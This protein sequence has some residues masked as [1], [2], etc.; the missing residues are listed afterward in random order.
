MKLTRKEF[1]G[2][3]AASGAGSII[4]SGVTPAAAAS[5]KLEKA[6]IKGATAA[7]ARFIRQTTIG[8]APSAAVV[9]AK[10]CLIDGFGVMLAGSTVH[11]SAED[12]FARNRTVPG[13]VPVTV[14]A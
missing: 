12:S 13:T 14:G 3:V 5:K 7:V 4:G 2:V 11:G 1:F 6:A 10:R 9:Q 8:D